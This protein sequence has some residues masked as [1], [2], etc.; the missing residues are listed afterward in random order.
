MQR[1]LDQQ[2]PYLSICPFD[3]RCEHMWH[4]TTTEEICFPTPICVSH[5]THRP[6][7][8]R[9]MTGD[10]KAHDDDFLPK[11]K[12]NLNQRALPLEWE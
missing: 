4:N 10:G 3:D 9:D 5:T 2:I 11:R 8:R 12:K 1:Q 6:P 7:W